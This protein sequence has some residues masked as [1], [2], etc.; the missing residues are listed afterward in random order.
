M[1]LRRRAR[2]HQRYW[3]RSRLGVPPPRSAGGC[4]ADAAAGAHSAATEPAA[5]HA[6]RHHPAAEA[7]GRRTDQCPELTTSSRPKYL[8]AGSFSRGET[9]P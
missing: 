1:P 4:E 5:G 6:Y 2:G 8:R 3:D 9:P 7:G